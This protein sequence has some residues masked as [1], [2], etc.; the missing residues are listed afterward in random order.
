MKINQDNLESGELSTGKSELKF[1]YNQDKFTLNREEPK[2]VYLSY[3][4]LH[5]EK[6]GWSLAGS[7]KEAIESRLNGK[8]ILTFREADVLARKFADLN[9]SGFIALM[10][11]PEFA[12]Y[13]TEDNE[14]GEDIW[15][16]RHRYNK[17]LKWKKEVRPNKSEAEQIVGDQQLTKLI[18][19]MIDKG[20]PPWAEEIEDGFSTELT[21]PEYLTWDQYT[22]ARKKGPLKEKE[23]ENA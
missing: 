16:L 10:I 3:G 6:H 9:D 19:A 15:Y 1:K 20:L 14:G 17:G 23:P 21:K 18:T 7:V 11:G 8:K 22:K 5:A 13:V 2:R 4:R 12:G